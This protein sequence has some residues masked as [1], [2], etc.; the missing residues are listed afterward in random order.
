MG[1]DFLVTEPMKDFLPLVTTKAMVGEGALGSQLAPPLGYLVIAISLH[2]PLWKEGD[3][4]G[5]WTFSRLLASKPPHLLRPFS[6]PSSRHVSQSEH[7]IPVLS[8]QDSLE[9]AY[10]RKAREHPDGLRDSVPSS[11]P[12]CASVPATWRAKVGCAQVPWARKLG[13][14]TAPAGVQCGQG[15]LHLAP[16]TC[17]TRRLSLKRDVFS[18]SAPH[19]EQKGGKVGVSKAPPLTCPIYIRSGWIGTLRG[20]HTV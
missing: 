17:P 2:G 10:P 13:L 19:S 11:F 12:A 5:L 3:V 8:A 7:Q 9:K 14:K 16:S 20:E 18:F 6:R 1:S 15:S 4:P